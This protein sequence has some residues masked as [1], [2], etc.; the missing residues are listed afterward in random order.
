MENPP[1]LPLMV[2]V[3]AGIGA[4]CVTP[5]G[6]AAPDGVPDAPS[7]YV[8]LAALVLAL[9]A[10]HLRPARSWLWLT[11]A[12]ALCTVPNLVSLLASGY[13]EDGWHLVLNAAARPLL[14]VGLLGAATYVWHSG[15]RQTGA[16][17]VA[18]VLV[19]PPLSG[20][21]LTN[22]SADA[23]QAVLVAGLVCVGLTAAVRAGVAQ[24]DAPAPGWRVT[25]A[26]AAAWVATGIDHWWPAPNP[27]R[28]EQFNGMADYLTEFGRHSLY[29][30]IA[31]LAVGLVAGVVAGTRV[32]VAGLIGGLV[33][34]SL[35]V[36]ITVSWVKVRLIDLPMV[37]PLLL[38]AGVLAAGVLLARSRAR[39]PLGAGLL[40]AAAVG[41]LLLYL[42]HDGDPTPEADSVLLALPLALLL[43]GCLPVFAA[44]G[45]VLAPAGEAP[46]ALAGVVTAI[47]GGTAGIANY[48]GFTDVVAASGAR[49]VYPAL[50]VCLVVA[51][52]LTV[53]G[54]RRDRT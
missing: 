36:L 38:A 39:E 53:F 52:G 40:G 32:L 44:L 15:G 30:G 12:G 46:A 26:G 10:W 7:T 20:L 51:T 42:E 33:L 21:V 34:G 25:L 23:L 47:A 3:A 2:G 45:S 8:R 41:L 24:T 4:L 9:V 43:V 1:R 37:V 49:A 35:S 31:L 5:L 19:V 6:V 54:V 28:P 13:A 16:V 27:F 11:I 48:F 17:L 22:V 50:M 29:T 18:A 14:L